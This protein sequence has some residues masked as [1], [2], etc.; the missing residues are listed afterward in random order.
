MRGNIVKAMGRDTTGTRLIG[1]RAFPTSP[2]QDGGEEARFLPAQTL[3]RE[4]TCA[5]EVRSGT[6]N[7]AAYARGA[8]ALNHGLQTQG[9]LAP[10]NPPSPRTSGRTYNFEAMAIIAGLNGVSPLVAGIDNR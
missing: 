8:P 4:S 6:R 9:Y 10:L 1:Q 5:Q 3:H 2:I 7:L